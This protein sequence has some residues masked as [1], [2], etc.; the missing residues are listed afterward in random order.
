MQ[1]FRVGVEGLLSEI[2]LQVVRAGGTPAG[3]LHASLYRGDYAGVDGQFSTPGVAPIAAPGSFVADTLRLVSDLPTLADAQNGAFAAF[4]LSGLNLQVHVGDVFSILLDL[5]AGS[6]RLGW[7]LGYTDANS[8]IVGQTYAGG[9]GAISQDGG[10]H[11]FGASLDRGFRTLVNAQPVPEPATW[12]LMIAG[13]GLAG[14]SLRRRR[15]VA[16]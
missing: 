2:D 13:F 3:S 15:A 5:P 12:A 16:A 14:A 4:D 11:F 1:T 8:N 7:V 6:S 9:Y 10:A